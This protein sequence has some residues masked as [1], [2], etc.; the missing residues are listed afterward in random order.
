M[1]D[2]G[3]ANVGVRLGTV[4]GAVAI[5]SWTDIASAL[6]AIYTLLLM[7]EWLWKKAVRP[8]MEKHGLLKRKQRRAT[9]TKPKS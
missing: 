5:T 8:L 6:A 1:N 9:D 3:V 7:G 4:W 2:D